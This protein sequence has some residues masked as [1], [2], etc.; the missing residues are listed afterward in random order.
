MPLKYIKS[1]LK[2]RDRQVRLGL[3]VLLVGVFVWFLLYM[4][5]ESFRQ[6]IIERIRNSVGGQVELKS[7]E[8]SLSGQL[9]LEKLTIAAES[10]EYDDAILRAKKII[11]KFDRSD[12]LAMKV[13]VTKVTVQDFIFNALHSNDTDEWNLGR[14]KFALSKK[15]SKPL[16]KIELKT[17]QRNSTSYN[18]N[19]TF[20]TTTTGWVY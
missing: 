17:D 14:L 4:A 10:K 19:L 12:L 1:F 8:L 13:N 5:G 20:E 3:L 11:I 18:I 16:P 7:A 6:I 15:G 2:A 9:V